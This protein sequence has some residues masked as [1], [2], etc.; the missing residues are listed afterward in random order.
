MFSSLRLRL[1]L[2]YLV[3]VAVVIGIIAFALFIYLLRN[4]E[5]Q[6]L[7]GQR[8]RLIATLIFQRGELL[9]LKLE[10]QP[11]EHLQ[12]LAERA[13]A[14]F[15]VRV[16]VYDAQ[17]RLVIDS[18]AGGP[19]FPSSLLPLQNS[20]TPP[21]VADASGRI[22]LYADH[23]LGGGATLVVAAPR[24]RTPLLGILRDEFRL[25]V[26]QAGVVALVLALLLAFWIANW[27]AAP[28]HRMADTA[29]RMAASDSLADIPLIPI[30]GPQEVRLLGEAFNEM[31]ARLQA[32]QQSQRDF[33][34]NVSHEL[35]TPLTSIQGFAQAILDGAAATPE[36]LQQAAQVI[37]T[38]AGRM[39]RLVLDLLELAR[40]E[41]GLGNLEI[42]QVQV[43]DLLQ[44]LA[45][46]FSLQARQAQ[47]D[48]QV[49]LAPLPEISADP[50]RLAQVFD[51]L[52]E[53]ALKFTPA[54][55]VVR[56]RSRQTGD[57]L[58]VSVADSGPGISDAELERVFERFYQADKSRA[59]NGQRGVGLG[60]AIARQ[61][62]QAHG[63]TIR[64]QHNQEPGFEQPGQPPQGS[65]FV[66]KIPFVRRSGTGELKRRF[67]RKPS[68]D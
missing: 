49:D 4:P 3:I 21:R 18:R 2:S 35:K 7:E 12:A 61:I 6:R 47:V 48:L 39:H 43:N 26:G 38:E 68:S 11:P 54:G 27:I 46:Q 29:R 13:D 57:F 20:A 51:N 53:N 63:G 41:A 16:V 62:V 58:E 37:Y 8:L 25:G 36:A 14:L 59:G 52:I 64:A 15:D 10:N 17:N 42:L 66:V 50:D 5:A 56:L 55:G 28:L 67:L 31:T 19:A 65:V 60:L 32:S 23:P 44:G 24:P 34:A 33:V 40:L 22:W 30:K 45:E 9:G 1:W